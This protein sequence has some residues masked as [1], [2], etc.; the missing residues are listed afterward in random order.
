VVGRT[1]LEEGVSDGAARKVWVRA[2]WALHTVVP[3]GWHTIVAPLV[4]FACIF[5]PE[6]KAKP[7]V[8]CCPASREWPMPSWVLQ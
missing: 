4:E 2:T 7:L 6:R 5:L 8:A 1:V 3:K